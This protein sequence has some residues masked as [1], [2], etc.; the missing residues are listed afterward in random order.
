MEQLQEKI[1]YH[2]LYD[3]YGGLLTDKQ[4]S[5][6]SYYYFDDYSLSEISKIMNVSRNAVFEQIKTVIGI[7]DY[8]E[9]KLNVLKRR[10]RRQYHFKQNRGS[11]TKKQLAELID[12]LEKIEGYNGI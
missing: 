9:E 2:Q 11:M 7:L 1:R 3:I 12:E 4:K 5:Y 10:E 6:F 8:Y